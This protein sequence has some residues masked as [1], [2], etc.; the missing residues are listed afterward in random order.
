MTDFCANKHQ[1]TALPFRVDV[2]V[3]GDS[4]L[5]V[6]QL[7]GEYK[8]KHPTLKV[9]YAQV[10]ELVQNLSKLCTLTIEYQHVLRA[11]NSIADG[12]LRNSVR[13]TGFFSPDSALSFCLPILRQ[14]W[15]IKPWMH[16]RIGLRLMQTTTTMM[17]EQKA[18]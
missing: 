13:G 14:V 12:T 4:Q 9:Y 5:I 10:H 7:R 15:P 6:K 1:S 2:I 3:Q 8:C 17:N 16:K 11:Y 18:F